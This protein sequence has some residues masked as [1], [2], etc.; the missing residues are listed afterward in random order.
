MNCTCPS[1][2]GSLRWPCPKHP[3]EYLQT[4]GGWRPAR[5]IEEL[6]QRRTPQL[7][8]S[9]TLRVD[10]KMDPVEKIAVD[11]PLQGKHLT[12]CSSSSLAFRIG[13]WRAGRYVYDRARDYFKWSPS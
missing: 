11:G 9:G 4:P 6:I 2:D 5:T 1:G 8:P 3:P 7:Y 12:L 13:L 10:E